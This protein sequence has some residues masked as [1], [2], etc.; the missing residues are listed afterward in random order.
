MSSVWYDGSKD[1]GYSFCPKKNDIL[2][3]LEQIVKE[4]K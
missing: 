4:V 1:C 3:I 2:G